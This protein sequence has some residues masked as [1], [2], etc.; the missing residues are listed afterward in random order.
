MATHTHTHTHAHTH[1]AVNKVNFTLYATAKFVD[2]FLDI[3]RIITSTIKL[4]IK[5]E[6]GL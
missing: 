3:F 5:C 2:H 4:K 1:R 6:G